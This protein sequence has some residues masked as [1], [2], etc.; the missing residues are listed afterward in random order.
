M[1]PQGTNE[2]TLAYRFDIAGLRYIAVAFEI[3]RDA[4]GR[5]DVCFSRS[6]YRHPLQYMR[7]TPSIRKDPTFS[8]LQGYVV[9]ATQQVL[10]PI[11]SYRSG[12]SIQYIDRT[13][14]LVAG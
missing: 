12:R 2:L 9:H 3:V 6:P 5:A 11:Q 13:R 4:S 14:E 1:L 7:R 10:F 8:Y